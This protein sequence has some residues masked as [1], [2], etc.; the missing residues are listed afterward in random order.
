M[1]NCV[2]PSAFP[3]PPAFTF[4]TL[5][6]NTIRS[7]RYKDIDLSVFKTFSVYRETSLQFRAESFNLTNTAV[8]CSSCKYRRLT[9]LW[10]CFSYGKYAK[11][12]AICA[13]A[14]VLISDRHKLAL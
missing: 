4:G 5:P 7:D 8:F 9:Y 3:A 11:A 10:N 1:S 6:T 2:N 13:Q 14:P 12:D